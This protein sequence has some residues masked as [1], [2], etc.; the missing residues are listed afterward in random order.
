MLTATEN[1]SPKKEVKYKVCLYG[2]KEILLN[3]LSW[4]QRRRIK[5]SF[6]EE[7]AL[8]QDRRHKGE[9]AGVHKALI[10]E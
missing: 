10:L 2:S 1:D 4:Q 3:S 8:M 7:M 5:D 6:L 9:S